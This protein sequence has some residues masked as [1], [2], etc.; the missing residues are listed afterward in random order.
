MSIYLGDIPLAGGGT[1]DQTYDATSTNAQSGTAVA[2]LLEAIYPVGSV[3][4]TTAN[5]CP[6]ST[7]ISGSTWTLISS[8]VV[9]S[10][11][12]NVP[13]KGTGKSLGLTNGTV[14]SGLSWSTTSVNHLT[15]M[16]AS[17][18][19][20]VGYTPSTTAPSWHNPTTIGVITDDSKS[21]IVGTTTSTTLSVNIYER[22]A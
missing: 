17:F 7:L 8:G 11:D 21:G 12:T 15:S 16:S 1:V 9:T 14:N 5:T 2:G 3:Y 10:V 18:D 22:T 6:L 20:N 4:I 13:I 19:K